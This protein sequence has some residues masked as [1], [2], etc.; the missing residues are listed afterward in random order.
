MSDPR[1]NLPDPDDDV[2]EKP[3][4]EY[5]QRID[6]LATEARREREAFEPPA[7]PPD[8]DRAMEYLRE[9]LGPVVM[10]YVDAH[11]GGGWTEFSQSELDSLHAATNDYLELYAACHGVDIEAE[12]TVR[13]A[14]EVLIETHNVRDVAQLL[15][16]VP[17]RGN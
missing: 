17:D 9:G 6:R 14:A 4:S 11:G 16:Q 12:F 7:D 3:D 5:A 1:K 13:E 8:E 2:P 15:T 10:V